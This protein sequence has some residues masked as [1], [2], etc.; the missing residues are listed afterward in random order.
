[1]KRHNPSL[2]ATFLLLALVIPAARAPGATATHVGIDEETNDAWRSTDVVKPFGDA[3]N[4]YGTDGW[5]IAQYPNGDPNNQQDPTYGTIQSAA[6]LLYEG[7]GAEAHQSVFDDVTAAPGPGL[8]NLVAGDYYQDGGGVQQYQPFF[9]FTL[10]QAGSF[11]L[12]VIGDQ[13]PDNPAN[14]FW[15]A[16]SGVQ[17]TGPGGADSGPIYI[18]GP[19]AGD[20]SWRDGDVDYVLFDI[21]GEVGD[22]F[23]ILGENDPRWSANA[24]GGIFLDPASNPNAPV[25]ASF[26]ADPTETD[27][28]GTAVNFT[29]QVEV[30]LDSLLLQPGDIDVFTNDTNPG[31]GAGSFTLDP[32]PDETTTYSLE[33]TLAGETG[34]ATV[35]VAITPP[36]IVSFTASPLAIAPGQTSTLSWEVA[37]PYTTLTLQPGDVDVLVDTN[38]GGV[39]SRVV[40]PAGSTTYQLVA[41][42]GPSATTTAD[43]TVQVRTPG[44]GITIV[45]VDFETNDAWRTTDVIKPFGDIDNVYGT[46]GYLIAQHG[47]GGPNGD[48]SNISQ[49][50][51]ATAEL[52]PGL[53]YEGGAS[54]QTHQAVF[55]DI[56]EAP[57]PGPINNAIC[58]DYYRSGNGT[59]GLVSEF[60]T[61]T[62]TEDASF[63]LGVICDQTTNVPSNL[64]WE[65]SRSV[66]VTGPDGADTG[67]VY[68][69]GP[70]PGDES[71]RNGDVEYALFD[72][73]G[74]AGDVFTVWGEN[75]S[76]WAANALGGV[77]FDPTG[78]PRGPRFSVERSGDDLLFK[79]D[80]QGGKLY[81][82]LSETD[83]S[84]AEPIDWTVFGSHQDI[85]ATP[86][87]NTLTIPYPAD[88]KRFFVISEFNAP[89]AS[90]FEEDFEGG[91]GVW[92]TGSE[93][94]LGTLWQV[95]APTN[96]GPAAAHGGNGQCYGTNI[97]GDYTIN[98]VVWLRSPPIDLT[99]ASGATLNFFHFVNIEEGFDFGTVSVLDATDDSPIAEIATGIDEQGP[100]DWEQFTK[101]IPAAA[102]GKEIKIEFCLFT[103]DFDDPGLGPFAGWYIDDVLVTVP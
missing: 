51:Y 22:E 33:A 71:W 17:V 8:A 58:G 48:A 30:P 32:G 102:L 99:N 61:I 82:L 46:D 54:K 39:G 14:L 31:T 60:F 7:V 29:W 70:S 2:A 95:G 85:E 86:P 72:M 84:V 55:D 25:I 69:A 77:F 76:R 52:I 62:L 41:V 97:A 67:L 56:L 5:L 78:G 50:P 80:S 24:L 19:T 74:S 45:G 98:T 6:G 88:A 96:V 28:P 27:T 47:E 21:T 93:G 75:D 15:E 64:F 44:Q 38:A 49:P 18:G 9:T 87:E 20:E 40:T 83:P 73:S 101:T 79:W 4:V 89:P 53:L 92:T 57:G 12:G 100:T 42:R 34:T 94:D 23:I 43:V 10:S 13:T 26:D 63:R 37:P 11:R 1:M 81:N 36:E 68:V 16:S 3:D 35:R 103:D 59:D 66:Q 90:I 65:A 91:G